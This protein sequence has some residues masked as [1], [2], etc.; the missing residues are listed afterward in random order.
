MPMNFFFHLISLQYSFSFGLE[1]KINKN[2]RDRPINFN[3]RI[4]TNVDYP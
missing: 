3:L 1:I 4:L 2:I